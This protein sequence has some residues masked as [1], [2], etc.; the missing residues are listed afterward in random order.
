MDSDILTQ[1]ADTAMYSAKEFGGNQF[2]IF[3]EQQNSIVKENFQ[4]EQ[5]LRRAIEKN[6]MYMVYQPQYCVQTQKII[7]YE[8]LIRWQPANKLPISPLR[9]IHIAELTGYIDDLGMWIIN[10]VFAQINTWKVRKFDFNKISINLSRVQLIE[11]NLSKI[12][13]ILMKK[14]NIDCSEIVFEITEDS[15]ISNNKVAMNNLNK[16]HKAGI[17]IAIDDFGTGYS[18]F[19]DLQNFPFSDLKIDKSIIDGIGKQESNDAIVRAI[20]AIGKE[21]KMNIVAEGVESNEQLEFLKKNHCNSIQGY[22]F[23]PP[24]KVSEIG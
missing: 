12:I 22:I 24:K 6:E 4:I 20:I 2:V 21:M 14:F 10:E 16:L 7:G 8:A 9:F 1:F 17:N 5:D 11:S 19:F 3:N 15:I 23:S 18:S 13:F